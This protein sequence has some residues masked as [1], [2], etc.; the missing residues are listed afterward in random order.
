MSDNDVKKTCDECGRAVAKI[1]R[2]FNGIRYCA[3]CY[4]RVFV[5][6]P[7][8]Q[9]TLP[10]RLPKNNDAAI[11]DNC[12][13]AKPCV[14]CGRSNLVIGKMTVYGPV[15]NSCSVYFRTPR[16]CG[17]CQRPSIRL[18]EVGRLG[19]KVQLCERCARSDYRS[20]GRC[21]RHRLLV[22]TQNELEI[23]KKCATH[24]DTLCGFCGIAVPAGRGAQCERCYWEKTLKNRIVL[25]KSAFSNIVMERNFELFGTW[26]LQRIGAHKAA[27][28]I[29]KYVPFFQE[30]EKKWNKI[31]S[32]EFLLEAFGQ[33]SL[34]KLKPALEWM[35]SQ[36]LLLL[37]DEAKQVHL[38]E[39]L[40]GRYL[41][42]VPQQ[43]LARVPLNRY[44]D[45]LIEKKQIGKTSLRSIRLALRPAA[46]LQK[47]A[48]ESGL[49]FPTQMQLDTFLVE[50]P[51]QEAAITGFIN[52]LIKENALNLELRV[53]S[54]KHKAHRRKL[55]EK[56]I[57][58]LIMSGRK[59]EG[60]LKK[61][62]KIS[63]EYFHGVPKSTAAKISHEAVVENEDG[64]YTIRIGGEDYWIPEINQTSSLRSISGRS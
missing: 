51:G 58:N 56:S 27:L 19:I 63:L 59:D 17:I 60:A 43:S 4:E 50:R 48:Y 23:C 13:K 15:C 28:T 52:F 6:K 26:L 54:K 12:E 5:K 45:Y 11:C 1:K 39:R 29:N 40:I 34:K 61:W 55:L 7:C 32:Y 21:G 36:K 9:C 46:T 41:D 31:P 22:A 53:D 14:R 2:V 47:M 49:E 57:V 62:I 38:D 64:S 42:S 3:A 18:S 10:F 24:E 33:E 8:A 44:R 30:V 35:S 20:C 25:N 37:N 16:P